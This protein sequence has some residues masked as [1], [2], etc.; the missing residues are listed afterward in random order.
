MFF[1]G[2][3]KVLKVQQLRDNFTIMLFL[4]Q[5]VISLLSLA[6]LVLHLGITK[7]VLS[8][9]VKKFCP[10]HRGNTWSAMRVTTVGIEQ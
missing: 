5:N 8:V 2:G 3:Y 4:F 7:L 6:L 9:S 1:L 10:L